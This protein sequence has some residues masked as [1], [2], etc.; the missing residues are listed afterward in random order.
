MLATIKRSVRAIASIQAAMD[1]GERDEGNGD[2][3]FNLKVVRKIVSV[4]S[5]LYSHTM[6]IF[7]I[8]LV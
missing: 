2:K 4:L 8:S 3:G 7:M 5:T 6:R 1:D